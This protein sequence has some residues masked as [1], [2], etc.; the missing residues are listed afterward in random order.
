[1]THAVTIARPPQ[2]VWPWLV[3]MGAGRAG[4]YSH[5]W[6]DNGRRRSAEQIVSALQQLDVG[7]LMPA[8]PG[9]TDG[10]T[11][12]RVDDGR[13]LVIG[14]ILPDGTRMMTWAFVLE[15]APEGT[16]LLVR[17]RGSS[18]YRFHG[19]PRW[20]TMP[21][22]RPIHFLMQRKQLLGVARRAERS[23][24]NPTLDRFIPHYDVREH[25]QLP[26]AAPASTTFVAARTLDL[27]RS[28]LI[29]ALFSTRA[30]VM[31][32]TA[33]PKRSHGRSFVEY[34][35]SLGWGLLHE[36][37]GHELVMGAVTRP[38]EAD[39]TF[40]A[41]PADQFA[42]FAE[43]D[44]VKI[45]WTLRADAVSEHRSIVRTETRVATTDAG[46]RARFRRYWAGAAPGIILIRRIAL[47]LVR[48][49]AERRAR[50][51]SA[52]AA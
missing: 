41:I 22:V 23:A 20:A 34:A 47:R 21:T 50:Q 11:V 52:A 28:G 7:D 5:D 40:R 48:G 9:V 1:M 44:Y 29:R 19:L 43:P 2:D 31:G 16:R 39:V 37:P 17:V 13:S 51:V 38:W 15:P 8:L 3:Q 42:A 27:E 12:L 32:A 18:A 10:F 26:V 14:W 36:T 49:D 24:A 46:A 35:Q 6:I 33:V 45:V 25:H 4:W 30:R